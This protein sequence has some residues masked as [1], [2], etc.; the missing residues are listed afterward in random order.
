MVAANLAHIDAVAARVAADLKLSA[1]KPEPSEDVD[2]HRNAPQPHPDCLYG[3]VG[4]I[5][6]A[7]SENTE[8]N[9]YGIAAAALAYLGVAVGRGPYMPIGDDWNHARLFFTFKPRAKGHREKA[10]HQT[11]RAGRQRD[12]S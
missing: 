11:H 6:R 10:G 4:E 7:G 12:A 9:P 5:A 2:H 3:L 8:A 1:V